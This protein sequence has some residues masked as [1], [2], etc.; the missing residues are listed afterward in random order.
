MLRAGRSGA[1]PADADRRRAGEERDLSPNEFALLEA[2][3]RAAPAP[4]SAEDLLAQVWDRTPTPSPRPSKSRC[5]GSA[6]KSETR[7]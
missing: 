4:L 2:L 6:A 3:I 5:V 7:T 1:Q